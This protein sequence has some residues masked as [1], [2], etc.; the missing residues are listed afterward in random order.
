MVG[1]S[2]KKE[3]ETDQVG[4]EDELEIREADNACRNNENPGQTHISGC[5]K[6]SEG[7]AV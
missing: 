3:V 1:A 7:I 2:T 4:F 5:V 6:H